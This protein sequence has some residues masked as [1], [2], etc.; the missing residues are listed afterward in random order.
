LHKGLVVSVGRTNVRCVDQE[1]E[2]AVVTRRFAATAAL[3]ALTL[4][5]QRQHQS[6]CTVAAYGTQVHHTNGWR[7]DHG[8][9]N[10]DEETLA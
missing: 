8:Q 6:G 3:A 10:T 9:T 5:R 4:P 1:A 2:A 7:K